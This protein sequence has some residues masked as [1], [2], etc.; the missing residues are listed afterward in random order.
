MKKKLLSFL[1]AICLV[2]PCL[3]LVGCG[4][5]KSSKVMTLKVN[6]EIEFVLDENNKVVSVN[7][8][9]EDCYAILTAKVDGEDVEVRAKLVGMQADDAAELF[10]KVCDQEHFIQV[11]TTSKVEI[12][13]SGEKVNNL[14]KEVKSAIENISLEVE[15][16][17]KNIVLECEELAKITKEELVATAKE[18]YKELSDDYLNGLTEEEL[19]A[20]IKESRDET[21]EFL[22]T[23]M[24]EF[25]YQ[26]RDKYIMLARLEAA[27]A[28]GA[29]TTAISN[30]KGYITTIASDFEEKY[31]SAKSE[32]QTQATQYINAKKEW[33]AQNVA[34]ATEKSFEKV[35][36]ALTNAQ[37]ALNKAMATAQAAINNALNTISTT[38]Q[39]IENQ[40]LEVVSK[41]P[42]YT[43][44]LET[45]LNEKMTELE[46]Y[47]KPTGEYG[48]FNTNYW[49]QTA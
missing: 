37:T 1:V 7:A 20:K 34:G 31:F 21:K 44:A 38:L 40:L 17:A 16:T 24:K 30:L 47:F 22:N 18:C 10:I 15:G 48:K 42:G 13:I 23:Q 46:N 32:F 4:D 3:C 8:L 33:L 28:L 25:Y 9:N 6:P 27:N 49:E 19:I 41:I 12:S 29:F 45:K 36:I 43:Q 14:Y 11:N 35:N 26:M 2:I 5:T 39:S